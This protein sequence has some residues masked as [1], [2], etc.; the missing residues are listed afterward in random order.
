M[1]LLL[2]G[3][4]GKTLDLKNN[5][6]NNIVIDKFSFKELE[7]KGIKEKKLW[8]TFYYLSVVK[9][10]SNGLYLTD[11]HNKKIGQPIS[12]YNWCQAAMEGA[13]LIAS[14]QGDEK[15]Y[16]YEDSNSNK[17]VDCVKILDIKK[18]KENFRALGHS[19]F[20]LSDGKYGK[21]VTNYNLV[22][23]RTIAVDDKYIKYGTVIYIPKARGTKVVL[24]SG[25]T[26]IHDG[27]FFAGDTGGAIKK[28]H[29]D[30]FYGISAK[31]IFS[32]VKSTKKFSFKAYIVK[33]KKIINYMKKLHR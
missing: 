29:V 9:E 27:Y 3:C 19:R 16:N 25:K 11:K 1:G 30:F 7:V 20:F 8:G 24:P 33:D 22:P 17:N 15:T 6:V 28:H 23:Y 5:K 31:H 13:I 32:F 18:N 21:G 14:K 4:Q 12:P 10:Q 26:I 2:L